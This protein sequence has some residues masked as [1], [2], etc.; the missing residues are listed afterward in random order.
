MKKDKILLLTHIAAPLSK[1][2]K[3]RVKISYFQANFVS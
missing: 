3:K 1:N 2:H